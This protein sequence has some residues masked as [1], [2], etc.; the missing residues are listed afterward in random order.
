MQNL[1]FISTFCLHCIAFVFILYCCMDEKNLN[2]KKGKSGK[3]FI[4]VD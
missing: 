1:Y 2:K 4:E 3:R